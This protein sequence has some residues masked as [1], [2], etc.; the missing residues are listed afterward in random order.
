[1]IHP[2]IRISGDASLTPSSPPFS[3]PWVPWLVYL[4]LTSIRA[5]LLQVLGLSGQLSSVKAPW[6]LIP[7]RYMAFGSIFVIP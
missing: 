2:Y 1:M 4:V 7:P 6:N 5:H 3:V